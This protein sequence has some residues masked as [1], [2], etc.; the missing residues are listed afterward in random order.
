MRTL[1]TAAV[2]LFACA[3]LA[4][5]R[6]NEHAAQD[7]FNRANAEY[8][9]QR[10]AEARALYGQIIDAGIESADLF[11]NMGN[12]SARL[13][14]TGEAVLY[15]EKARKLAPR[16]SDVRANLRRVGPP[17]NDPQRFV[18]AV[19]LF[20]ILEKLSLREW[21]GTFLTLFVLM[22]I[23]GAVYYGFPPPRW[24]W[25]VRNAFR[26]MAVASAVLALFAA[27][28]LYQSHRV[29]HSVVMRSN[30]P[31]YSGPGE[32]FS[33]VGATPEGT[34]VRRLA[35]NDPVWAQVQLMDGQRGFVVANSL[36]PI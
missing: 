20:W 2:L 17:D 26:A 12:A 36:R 9:Q 15:Y 7:L 25:L 28:K 11:Y 30:A 33:Q 21:V 23:T 3:A 16:D 19:P 27:A 4:Q 24:A 1:A 6:M 13:G 10:Y 35:F 22:G 5:P 14:R 34:K 18:L 29:E 32:R 31:V 8:Q